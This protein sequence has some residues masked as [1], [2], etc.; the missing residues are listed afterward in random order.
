MKLVAER[1]KNEHNILF[2]DTVNRENLC[3]YVEST[4]V[5]LIDSESLSTVT[6]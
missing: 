3:G 4:G 1:T 6:K 2:C 5:Y